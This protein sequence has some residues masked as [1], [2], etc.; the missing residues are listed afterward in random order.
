MSVEFN[1]RLSDE[2]SLS[3][4]T[5]TMLDIDE[6]DPIRTTWRD[7]FIGVKLTRGF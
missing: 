1:R 6:A 7:S 3:L 5:T 4:E 2:W